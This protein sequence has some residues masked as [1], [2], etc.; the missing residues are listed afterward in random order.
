VT[1][2]TTDHV[3]QGSATALQLP[4]QFQL[5]NGLPAVPVAPGRAVP[6]DGGPARSAVAPWAARLAQAVL[7]VVAAERPVT[8]LTSWVRPEIYQRLYRRQQLTSR[9]LDPSRPRGRCPDQVR[10][11][12]VCH[13]TPEIAE[14][15]VVTGGTR[16]CRAMALRLEQRKG[17][18]LCTEL[19][20]V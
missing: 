2:P 7:E 14:V 6:D 8:Q 18:W 9:Q 15:S 16:R 19:D 20:W 17:R 4:L 3:P 13:P 5:P 1:S 11:V 12:H 10:S